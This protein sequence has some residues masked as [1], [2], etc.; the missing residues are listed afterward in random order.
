M[1]SEAPTGASATESSPI[2]LPKLLRFLLLG[3]QNRENFMCQLDS[4]AF[5]AWYQVS[6]FSTFFVECTAAFE[7]IISQDFL[8]ANFDLADSIGVAFSMPDRNLVVI[9]FQG[10]HKPEDLTAWHQV[11][12]LADKAE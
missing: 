5:D 11:E 3:H 2:E 10:K 8:N 7:R 9:E 6:A 1:T 12:L 4:S